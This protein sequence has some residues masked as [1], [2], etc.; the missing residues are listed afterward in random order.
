M[1]K[2]YL[3]EQYQLLKD[4]ISILILV[5]TILGGIWQLLELSSI[6]TSFIRFFSLSQLVADGIL[7][8][9]ILSI[10]YASFKLSNKMIGKDHYKIN[11][12]TQPPKIWNPVV[13]IFGAVFFFYIVIL[14]L[15]EEIYKTRSI[16]IYEIALLIPLLMMTV[17]GFSIGV[18]RLKNNIVYH[19]IN[20][21]KNCLKKIQKRKEL[22]ENISYFSALGILV[23]FFF[24]LKILLVDLNPHMSNFRQYIIFPDDL[25]NREILEKKLINENC[26]KY[27]PKMIYNNDKYFFYEILDNKKNKKIL[28]VDYS[29]LTEK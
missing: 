17:D 13:L 10:I 7:I 23:L 14:P 16:R 6:S 28:I 12:N 15:L 21:I 29:R 1:K 9:F 22:I 20:C 24:L 26:L 25:L 27:K 8:L 19:N 11:T 3:K 2:T 5:P 18:L 4:N